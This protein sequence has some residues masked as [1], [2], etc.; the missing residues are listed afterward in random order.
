MKIPL[1]CQ[2]MAKEWYFLLAKYCLEEFKLDCQLRRLTPRTIKGYYN[3]TLNFLVYAE[4]HHDITEVEEIYTLHIKHYVQY[5]LSKK[6]TASY[7]NNILKCLRAYF[8]FAV[9]EEY[10][11]ANPTLKVKMQ[12]EPKVLIRTFNDDEV[13]TLL[14]VF[15]YSTFLSAR[16]KMVLAIAFDTG[17]RNTEI[18]EIKREDIRENVILLHGKGNKERHV[19]ISPYLKKVMLKYERMRDYYFDDK[20]IHDTNYLLSRTGRPL[21]KEALEHIFNQANQKAKVRDNIRCSPHTAR[22][23]FAQACLRNG[24]DLY[25]V[26]RLLGHENINITKRY[27][28][29]LEDHNIVEMAAKASPLFNLRM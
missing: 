14:S 19:P 15:D 20:I 7:T 24:L 3:N 4:K 21:T 23:Y 26:S 25:S 8:R 29:S 17:A 1:F 13:R 18:C 11:H 16:N 27:L 12:K 22:H 2:Q 6:L 10:I 28:Q 9:Q 5:L